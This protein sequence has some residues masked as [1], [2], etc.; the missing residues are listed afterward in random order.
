[1]TPDPTQTDST[2]RNAAPYWRGF[3]VQLFLLTIVLLLVAL[4]FQRKKNSQADSAHTDLSSS[5]NFGARTS[6][7]PPAASLNP[8]SHPPRSAEEIVAAKV[9][10]FGRNRRALVERL[11]AH[12]QKEIPAEIERFF[13]AIASGDWPETDRLF[14]S[15]AKRCAQYEGSTHDPTLDPFWPAVLE[16]YGAAEQAHDW[17]AQQLL[18]YSEAILGSLRPGMVYIGGTDPGRFIPTLINETSGGEQHVILTQNAFADARYQEYIRFLYGDRLQLPGAADVD[19][20][21]QEYL[22]DATRRLEHDEQFPNEPKQLRTREQVQR[23]DGKIEV[24]GADAVMDINE[25]VLQYILQNNPGLGFA[26]EESFPMKSTYE[27]ARP[28][29]PILE[30][31]AGESESSSSQPA[32]TIEYWREKTAQILQGGDTAQSQEVLNTWSKMIVG[33]ANLLSHQQH[34]ADAEQAYQLAL[35]VVPRNTDAIISL[36]QHYALTGRPDAARQLV[37]DFGR[38]HPDLKPDLDRFLPQF[39]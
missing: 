24:S 25:R 36:S 6:T 21:F 33:Q 17:P 10:Q 16:T 19:R 9:V 37:Q 4:L 20:T 31:R 8:I 30:L 22:A 1:M 28:L 38:R 35:Q 7:L 5:S 27:G 3:A 13:E 26:L 39:K 23:K 15:M 34:S 18:D 12:H 2:N 11:A 29:G 14:Q 32:Q